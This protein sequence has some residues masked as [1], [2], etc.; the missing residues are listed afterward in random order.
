MPHMCLTTNQNRN[1]MKTYVR[2][3]I[4]VKMEIV[5]TSRSALLVNNKERCV[6]SKMYW[7]SV[8]NLNIDSS[9]SD[10]ESVLRF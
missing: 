1:F 5:F 3:F 8:L 2:V 7:S 6:C 4:L 10:D 9:S